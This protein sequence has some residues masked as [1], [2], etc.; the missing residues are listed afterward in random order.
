[1]PVYRLT[2]VKYSERIGSP[3]EWVLDTLTLGSVNLIVGTNAAGKTRTVTVINSLAR[4]LLPDDPFRA[5]NAGYDVHFELGGRLLRYVI[6]VEDGRIVKEEFYQDGERLLERGPSGEG[7]IFATAL[8][9]SI[10]FK[11][12]ENELAAVVRRDSLQHPYLEPLHD[13]AQSVRHYIFGGS[14]C[15]AG[16]FL[17]SS[18]KVAR[19]PM[20]G[21]RQVVGIFQEGTPDPGAG[22]PRRGEAGYVEHGI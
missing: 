3:K 9:Q 19:N 20:R 6:Q 11:P 1:M 12:P 4:M 13:W 22:V 16:T 2:S 15:S 10:P 17:R 5:L 18:R 8:G 21:M 7:R 14:A